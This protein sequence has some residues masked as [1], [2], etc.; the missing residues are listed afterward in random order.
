MEL[1][2]LLQ[3]VDDNRVVPGWEGKIVGWV[4]EDVGQKFLPDDMA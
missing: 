1:I 3:V 2:L 4:E